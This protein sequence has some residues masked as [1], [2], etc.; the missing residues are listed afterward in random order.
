MAA[1][2]ALAAGAGEGLDTFLQRLML[3][4]QIEQ[5]AQ[6]EAE[7]NRHN[8][9]TEAQSSRALDVTDAERRSRDAALEAVRQDQNQAR[10]VTEGRT[11]GDTIPPKTF[12]SPDDPAV[13][14]MG[15]GGV[16][17][18]LQK[19]DERPQVDEGPLLPGDTGAS[20]LAGFIKLPSSSQ[21]KEAA[22]ETEKEAADKRA[23]ATLDERIR[24]DKGIENKPT[25]EP[26]PQPQFL[27]GPDGKDHAI[28]FIG[29]KAVEVPLPEGFSKPS[30]QE[31]ST[32]AS[33]VT[34]LAAVSR[35]DTDIDEADKMGLIG[36]ASG[37][38][39]DQFAKLG[40][41]GDPAKDAMIGRI[42]GDILLTKMHVD[43]GIGGARAA[44]SPL[45][46]KNW[47]DIAMKGSKDL[48]HGYTSAMRGDM[49]NSGATSDTGGVPQVGGT[50]NGGKVLKVTPIQ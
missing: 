6:A 4:Q 42:K 41:T 22:A 46:I 43:A 2:L 37:R 35:L 24:H 1:P 18:L 17:S 8:L 48:L 20:R 33:K 13:N 5:R 40:T 3:Q 14:M 29:G 47:E 32:A 16:L 44:A 30:S 23:Q 26:N 10:A 38:I 36:P 15:R 34:G 50:F 11:L 28:Q 19:Q 45:L 12:L 9:A 25:H 7:T 27:K 39:Y 31:R 21:A 49:G